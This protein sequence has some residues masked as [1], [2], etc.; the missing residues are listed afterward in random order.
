MGISTNSADKPRC[1]W[2]GDDALYR[3]YHDSEWGV[4][5]HDD[6]KL[7][8][9]LILEGFQAG[10]S[11]ITVLRK[12]EAFRDAFAQFDPH[13]V[14]RFT[15][16]DVERLMQNKAII[17]NRRKIECAVSNAQAFIA[18][19]KEFGSFDAYNW[20]FVDHQPIVNHWKTHADIPVHTPIAEA[21][22]KDLKKRGFKF[23]GPT[24]VYSH[25]QATGMVND[26]VVGCFR[27]AELS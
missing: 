21:F 22:S 23:V 18:I 15:A 24:V 19:Q 6:Q 10:L 5:L 8:E 11:W 12:R 27:H 25:M 7:F 2:C 14:A 20:S 13:K 1:Q 4:P 16:D 26:H 3:S 9:F 17:R